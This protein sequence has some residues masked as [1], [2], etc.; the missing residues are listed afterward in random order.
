MKTTDA[1]ISPHEKK[2]LSLMDVAGLLGLPSKDSAARLLK[3]LG[4]PRVIGAGRTYVLTSSFLARLGE[5]EEVPLTDAEI[6]RRAA[7][8]LKAIAP[9]ARSRRRRNKSPSRKRRSA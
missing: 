1:T 7:E 5:L 4:V 2:V 9:T 3:N 6:R 8:D